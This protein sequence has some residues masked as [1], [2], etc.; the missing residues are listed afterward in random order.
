MLIRKITSGFVTQVYDTQ[1]GRFVSQ[2]FTAGDDCQYEDERGE[3]VDSSLLNVH[4][5]EAYLPFQM[6]QPTDD[7]CAAV[8]ERLVEKASAAGLEPED[9]DETVHELASSI[10]ADINNGGLDEQVRYL[11]EEMGAEHTERQI[12]ELI[13]EHGKQADEE[14]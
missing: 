1:H 14:E 13:Q 11:V 10:A 12:D 2:E 4:G 5:H 7:E 9:M 3:A 8:V 6:V